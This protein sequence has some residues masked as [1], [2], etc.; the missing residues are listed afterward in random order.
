[1]QTNVQGVQQN[2]R[3]TLEGTTLEQQL[4]YGRITSTQT[5][6]LPKSFTAELSGFYQ[7]R[8]L[9]GVMTRRPFGALNVGLQKKLPNTRGTLRLSGEDV[10]WTNLLQLDTENKAE[11]YT[12]YF[13]GRAH[14]RLVRLTYSRTFGN[15]KVN[16]NNKR[17][18]GS[19]EERR[20]VN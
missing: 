19:D 4:L 2:A 8:S 12:A 16:V 9:Y 13:D 17:A 14:N 6:Q 10:L 15:Q 20:R 5:F 7:S 18:T 1:M 11:G 3:L